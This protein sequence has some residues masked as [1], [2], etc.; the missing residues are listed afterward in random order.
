M[1]FEENLKRIEEI[2]TKLEK[3]DT[4]LEESMKMFEE[5][6]LLTSECKKYLDKYKGKFDVIREELENDE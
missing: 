5:G 4:P 1:K 2:L 6:V 3:G